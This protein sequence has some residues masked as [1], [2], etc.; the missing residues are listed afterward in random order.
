MGEL[1]SKMEAD[2][3]R[4]NLA[5][6]TRERYLG[7]AKEF[8]RHY[9]KSPRD[10]GREQIVDYLRHLQTH[11]QATPATLKMSIAGIRFLYLVTLDR[12]DEVRNLGWPKVPR[13]LP[14]VLSQA[15]VERIFGAMTSLAART[16]LLVQYGC[17][18]RISEACG[19]RVEDIDSGRGLIRIERGKGGKDRYTT[20]GA[21]LLEALRAYWRVVR[22]NGPH[23]FPGRKPGRPITPS[24]VRVELDKA[25][26]RAGLHK[27]VTTHSLRHAF[28]THLLEAG[29]DVRVIQALLGHSSIRTTARY[30]HVSAQ[31]VATVPSPLDLLPSRRQKPTTR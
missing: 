21:G 24:A 19:L 17:G 27:R 25:V 13:S 11:E 23:L 29:T 15:E 20:L 7:C 28:A 16:I 8:V 12:P 26:E 31:H 30:T 3:R 22:P 6:G 9:M 4:K 18:A 14:V 5:D 10:L 2:L 1:Y